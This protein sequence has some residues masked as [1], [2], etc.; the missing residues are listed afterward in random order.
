MSV[1]INQTTII[2]YKLYYVTKD[3]KFVKSVLSLFSGNKA[4][5]EL[6]GQAQ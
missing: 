5:K 2:E 6:R 3:N 4:Y 1:D